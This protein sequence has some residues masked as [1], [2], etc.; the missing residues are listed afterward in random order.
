MEYLQTALEYIFDQQTLVQLAIFVVYGLLV[1]ALGMA[2]ILFFNR[3]SNVV[4][5]TPVGPYFASISVVFAL[6]LAFHGAHIWQNKAHAERAFIDAGIAIQRLDELLSPAQLD[7]AEPRQSLEHY[8]R[9]VFRDEWRKLRS[10]QPS[11]QAEQAFRD[12]QQH[13]VSAE[14]RLP[15]VSAAQVN[16]LLNEISRTR[17]DRLWAGANHTDTVS[18]LAVL[19]LGLLTQLAIAS[20]HFDK[21]RAGAVALVLLS[22]TT[23]MAYWSLGVADDPYRLMDDLG[24]SAWLVPAI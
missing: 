24:P 2:L 12:L 15:S 19:V 22:L 17:S 16:A 1:F 5:W 20:I 8:V 14:A 13:V 6:F 3:R 23:T 21:P 7:L 11:A 9:Y 4:R 10:R 18:W